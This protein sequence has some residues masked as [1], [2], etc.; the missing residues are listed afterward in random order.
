MSIEPSAIERA[1]EREI[2][3]QPFSGVVYVHEKGSIVFQMAFGMANRAESIPNSLHTR[4]AIASGCKIF[5]AVAVCRLVEQGKLTFDTRLRDC[6]DIPFPH[7]DANVTVHHLLTHSSGIPDYFDEE[8][9]DDYEALWQDRPMYRMRRLENFLPMFQQEKMAFTPGEKFTYNNS[10]FI[11]LGLIVEQLSG[12]IFTDYIRENIFSPAGMSDSGYF[13]TD[14]L[15]SRTA[16]GYIEDKSG[17][18]WRT[19]IFAVPIIGGAD[20]GAYTTAP[21]MARFWSALLGHKLLSKELTAKMMR[22][23]VEAKSEGEGKF[24]GY[25]VWIT[26]KHANIGSYYVT[27]WDPGVAMVSEY[28]PASDVLLTVIGNANKPV[29]PV[30]RAIL[31]VVGP[32]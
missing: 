1:I 14:R 5:T 19:N 9:N 11:V 32:S 28:F 2:T 20:G 21:D 30:Y 22:V 15:P 16:L 17:G 3:R 29:F 6:L 18:G 24:Y 26:K 8:K 27:G 25:G 7:F 13:A 12:K 10:G 31:G 23:H 4:F